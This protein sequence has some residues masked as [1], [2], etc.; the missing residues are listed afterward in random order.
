MNIGACGKK[1]RW[2]EGGYISGK[3]AKIN[4]KMESNMRVNS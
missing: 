1:E 3:V 4:F 2:R